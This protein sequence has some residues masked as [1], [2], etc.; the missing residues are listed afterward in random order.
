MISTDIKNWKKIHAVPSE[1]LKGITQ[2]SKET[3][4]CRHGPGEKVWIENCSS[5]KQSRAAATGANWREI[6]LIEWASK[7]TR[8]NLCHS[9]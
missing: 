4:T 3:E 5:A 1:S 8:Y 7:L 2:K 6:V 9:W